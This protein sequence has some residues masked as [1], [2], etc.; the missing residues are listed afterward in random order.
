[1]STLFSGCISIVYVYRWQECIKTWGLSYLF[2]E[3]CAPVSS[4]RGTLDGC[5]YD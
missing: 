3:L 4:A 5:A 1:M 2:S